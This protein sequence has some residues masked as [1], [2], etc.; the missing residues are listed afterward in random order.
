MD[1]KLHE[2]DSRDT[3]DRPL[4]KRP[5]SIDEIGGQF[6][7][8]T[9][10][11]RPKDFDRFQT[12]VKGQLEELNKAHKDLRRRFKEAGIDVDKDI[13]RTETLTESL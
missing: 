6:G 13:K 5:E 11:Q 8:S 7:F 10:G 9:P 3:I 4:A 12:S 2:S 1:S